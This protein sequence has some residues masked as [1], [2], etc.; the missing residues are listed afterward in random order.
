MTEKVC[1][2]DLAS[3]LQ[4]D[5][6]CLGTYAAKAVGTLILVGAFALKIPQIYNIYSTGEVVGLSPGAFY[7]EV[8]LSLVSVAYNFLQGNPFTSY[9]EGFIIM[10]QNLILV[11][12]LWCYMKPPPSTATIL[13]VLAMFSATTVI[14]LFMPRQYQYILPLTTMPMMIYSR[15]A[16]IIAN[17]Q[18]GTTG[19]LSIITSI[20]QFGGSVARIGTTI[21][22]VG[23]DISLLSV[24][25]ISTAL[26]G[27]LLAQII[28]YNYV[29]KPVAG[30]KKRKKKD[31]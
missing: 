30:D 22:E 12:M 6:D 4:F 23:W 16:Q 29:K 8:P 14:S 13:S 31:D 10:V 20:L 25:G 9:G 15:M 1:E 7:S 26:A 21:V 24:Y 11:I 3:V 17:Y 28:F 5:P 18:Q 2:L 27:I 19:Q